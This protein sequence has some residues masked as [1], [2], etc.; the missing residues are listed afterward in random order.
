MYLFSDFFVAA[1]VCCIIPLPVLAIFPLNALNNMVAAADAANAAGLASWLK[2][3]A[4]AEFCYSRPTLGMGSGLPL[5]GLIPSL[6]S[7]LQEL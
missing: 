5:S 3:A 4:A 6:S 1:D 7:P 2:I